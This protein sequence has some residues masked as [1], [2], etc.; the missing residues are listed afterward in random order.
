MSFI[1]DLIGAG[2]VGGTKSVLGG[3]GSLSQIKGTN[4]IWK[5]VGA[6]G[7]ALAPF[8]NE[9][10]RSLI[11]DPKGGDWDN[12]DSILDAFG[13]GSGGGS[14]SGGGFGGG[15]GELYPGDLGYGQLSPSQLSYQNML[16]GYGGSSGSGG[17][18]GGFG[19]FLSNLFGKA[20]SGAGNM[21]E[22]FGSPQTQLGAGF[23][24]G[25]LLKGL[26]KVPPL[27]DS[28]NQL[29]SQ[30]QAGGSPLGQLAQSKLTQQLGQEYD[31]LQQPEIDA[32]LRELERNQGIEEDKVRDLYRNLRPGTDPSSDSTFQKDLATVSDQF[33]R[34]KADTLATRTR[35]TKAIFDQQRAQQI[36]QALGASDTQ[37][38][39]LAQ[40][41]QLDVEQIMT[42]LDLDVAQA[43]YFKQAFGNL[44]GQLLLTGLQ[45]QSPLTN[46][47]V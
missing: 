33:S 25:S 22:L 29:R 18:G 14:S 34:A 6:V 3:L 4:P 9:I 41:A 39:Q 32:A 8:T 38:S 11:P 7:G 12:A 28:V 26:P 31:P 2:L 27:P 23:L 35:D 20:K 21:L 13:G 1:G 42:Q 36:Q 19:G 17:G 16:N 45:S 10:F 43:M 30:V 37:M 44:G 47:S 40:L 46:F 5:G 15:G 24:T